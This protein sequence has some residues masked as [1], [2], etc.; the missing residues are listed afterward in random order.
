MIRRALRPRSQFSRA[1]P[2]L[3]PCLVSVEFVIPPF[4]RDQFIVFPSLDN[5]AVFEN[6]N[7]VG[8]PDSTQAVSDDQGGP[9]EVT[10][11]VFFN[12]ELSGDLNFEV[13][14]ITIDHQ[15]VRVLFENDFINPVVIA[16]PPTNNGSDPVL[17]RIRNIDP[18]GDI[19]NNIP[20]GFEVRLQEWDYLEGSHTDETFSYIVMEKGVHTLYNEI[21]VEAGNFTGSSRFQKI[22]LQQAYDL[23]PIILTQIITE[24]ET[25]AVTGRIRKS[26]QSSF[27][28]KLQ[29]MEKTNRNHTT[30]TI[31]YIAWEPVAGDL[32][33]L[34]YEAGLTPDSVT[35][36]WFD[37]TFETD[38]LDQPLFIA[39][40]QTQDGRDTAVLRTQDLSPSSTQ[41]K[42][43][44]E[45]SKDEETR[46][47]SEVVGYL[48][49]GSK[50][51]I[52]SKTD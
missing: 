9:A 50:A 40:M 20:A 22:S 3:Y 18:V 17:I 29:E 32:S 14:K 43:E 19:D 26:G 46:H 36:N 35:H 8:P 16:G 23:T 48:I 52:S 31:G 1:A 47:T 27:E 30:E 15:W 24:N 6:Q 42:I 39:N 11:D 38:F 41:I 2:Q 21:K 37:L 5:A 28:Y 10:K 13:G 33:G 12:A 7:L 34:A 45:Q 4:A 51:D 49:I 25:D 44:E